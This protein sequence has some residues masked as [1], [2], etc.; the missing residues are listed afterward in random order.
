VHQPDGE[1]E[2]ERHT[3]RET[4]G[5]RK[6]NDGETKIEKQNGGARQVGREV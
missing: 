2:R 4:E 1:Q 6:K 5:E 3:D